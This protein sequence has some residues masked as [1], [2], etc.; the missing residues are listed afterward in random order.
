MASIAF[1]SFR[2]GGTDGVAIEAQKWMDALEILGHSC[3]TVA[4]DGPV[5]FRIPELAIGAA[6]APREDD[7]RAALAGAD[8]VIVENL[9][10]LPLNLL[11]RDAV[12]RALEGRPA[13]L[14]HHDLPWQRPHLAHLDGPR[15]TPAWAHVTINEISRQ[16]LAERGVPAD[17]IYNHFDV[18]P[19]AGDRAAVRATLRLGDERLMLF[20]SRVIARKNVAGA[21]ALASAVGATLWI[22]G[23]AEDGYDDALAAQIAASSTP[24]LQRGLGDFTIH[25]AYA[26]CDVVVV[27]STWEGFGNPV[28]ES[29]THQRPLAL[30]RYPVA[31][32]IVTKGFHFFDITD[33]PA[34]ERELDGPDLERRRANLTVAETHFN[35]R[36]LPARLDDV[37]T[38]HFGP[39][40]R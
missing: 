11:A 24:V 34:I 36:Q 1:V 18:T 8:L 40:K 37:L 14:H 19:P 28:L 31:N 4:G 9:C 5:T 26:A 39:F 35:I 3:Y 22:L 21:I 33:V 23:E 25:D 27:A 16:E 38:R 10:S 6:D 29:V 30:N 12:Y 7:L 2:L 15:N 13:L 20:P 17:V 32:E